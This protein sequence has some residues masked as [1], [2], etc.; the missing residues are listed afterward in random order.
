MAEGGQK[1][2]PTGHRTP[3]QVKRHGRT[4]QASKEQ[5]KKRGK[6]NAARKK[7][8]KEGK[9]SKGD[10]KDVDHKRPIKKGGGNSRK[11]LRVSSVKKNRGHGMSKNKGAKNGMSKS[12]KKPA[13]RKRM[14]KKT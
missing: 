11:N 13:I 14:S 1:R 6:R 2:S 12:Y 4:Y 9:V 10:G 8:E 3:G 7:L 5:I